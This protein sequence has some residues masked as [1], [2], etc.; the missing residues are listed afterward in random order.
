MIIFAVLTPGDNPKVEAAM[1][2]SFSG[3]YLKV[4][5]GQYLVAA[6]ATAVDVS[7]TLGISDG[8]NGAGIVLSTSSYFGRAE[9]TIWEWMRL[10]VSTP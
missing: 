5:P 6:K 10:K 4:G 8:K 1:G 7:N 3:N 9:T 2:V